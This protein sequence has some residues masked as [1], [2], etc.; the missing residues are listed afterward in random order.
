MN[1]LYR[2]SANKIVL[3]ET[4]YQEEVYFIY[5]LLRACARLQNIRLFDNISLTSFVVSSI[6]DILGSRAT[7]RFL[8]NHFLIQELRVFFGKL[9]EQAEQIF[10]RRFTKP[11]E[12]VYNGAEAC[13]SQSGKAAQ[14]GECD[15]VLV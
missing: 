2:I 10:R 12:I 15:G 8:R 13:V 11:T 7:I 3:L 4:V 9:N 1:L 14:E 5:S 6:H